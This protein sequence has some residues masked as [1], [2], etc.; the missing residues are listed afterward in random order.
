MLMVRTGRPKPTAPGRNLAIVPAQPASKLILR[1]IVDILG[2][3]AHLF[4]EIARNYHISILAQA[5]PD[6]GVPE[7]LTIEA[8]LFD[9]GRPVIV[10]P[11]I[12][13]AGI[14]LDRVMVCWDGSRAAARAIGDALPFR[15]RAGHIDVV[16]VAEKEL[17]HE[18]R[19]VNIAE[20]LARYNS[21]VELKS[22]VALNVDAGS[23]LLS[24]AADSAADLIVLGGYGHTR[25]GSLFSA[26]SLEP[27]SAV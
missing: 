12:Q 3:A 23:A 13:N 6:D 17:R 7:K 19:G 4:S 10:V 21:R 24:H 9:S 18:L 5:D 11:Y 25:C 20:H 2:D 15:A 1:V 16:T 14:K 22:I 26:G 8:A 27:F